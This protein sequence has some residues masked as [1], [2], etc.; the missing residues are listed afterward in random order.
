MKSVLNTDAFDRLRFERLFEMSENMQRIERNGRNTFPSIHPLMGDIWA[1]LFK[2]KPEILAEVPDDL[3]MN[4]QLMERIMT[5]KGFEEFREYTR[6]DDLTSALG[7]IKYSETVLKWIEDQVRQNQALENVLQQMM[8]GSNQHDQQASQALADALEQNGQS[9][10]QSIKSA[11]EETVQTKENLKSL[12]SGVKAGSGD[13]ELK[14]FP[15]RDQLKLAEHLSHDRKLKEISEWAGRMKLIAQKKQRS[16]HQESNDR[17]GIAMGNQVEML[18][19]TELA[20][21]ASPHTRLDFLR[22]FAEGQTLQYDSKGKEQLG[23]GPIVLCLDQSGSMTNQDTIAKGFALALMS[24]ARRQ[25]R[26]FALILFSDRARKPL[27]FPRGKIGV[28]DMIRLATTFLDGGTDFASPLKKASE[29]IQ[30]SRFRKADVVFVTDGEDRLT[31]DFVKHW[32]ELKASKDFRVLSL[33]IGTE[34]D[35]TVKKFSDRVVKASSLSD[36][37]AYAAFEI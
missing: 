17:S 7:T 5:D 31:E 26:D 1:S 24:I 3:Q 35:E 33:L 36:E 37:A 12:L 34:N 2:M 10:A 8:Q 4:K 9:L 15:L 28:D 30:S 19:P 22:R 18:L 14:K 16:K 25:S 32:N 6:L 13:A 20:S 23:K 29:V 27:V 11:A 21:F